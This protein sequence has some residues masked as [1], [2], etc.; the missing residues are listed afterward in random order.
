MK[1]MIKIVGLTIALFA[2]A[3]AQDVN[4][5][6]Q[7][8]MQY[9]EVSEFGVHVAGG[10]QGWDPS[11]T[12]MFDDDSDNIYTVVIALTP[13]D[14]HEYKF[15]NGNA[16]GQDE[17]VQRNITVSDVDTVVDVVFFDD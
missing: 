13:G 12:E 14:Y 4:I 7:V 10:F 9:Q 8:D 11:S 1:T 3:I 2:L 17:G 6:L 5:T 15:I 16:W